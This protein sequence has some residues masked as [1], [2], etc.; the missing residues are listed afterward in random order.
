MRSR[1]QVGG[2]FV[3][4]LWHASWEGGGRK[5]G[6]ERDAR[7]LE[8]RVGGR[9]RKLHAETRKVEKGRKEIRAGKRN[10]CYS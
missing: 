7:R 8:R 1:Q 9:K 5:K 10:M 3:I 2:S 6:E 4:G